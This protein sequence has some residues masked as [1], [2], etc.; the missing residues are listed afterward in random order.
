LPSLVFAD[1]SKTAYLS[2]ISV[3][4]IS[5]RS[6]VFAPVTVNV[7]VKIHISPPPLYSGISE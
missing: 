7:T 1:V 3:S 6:S 5:R 4:C 2:G